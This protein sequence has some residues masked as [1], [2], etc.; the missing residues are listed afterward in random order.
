MSYHTQSIRKLLDMMKKQELL[1]PAFQRKYVWG[2]DRVESL[3]D[4]LMRGYPIGTFLFWEIE[5]E[6][7]N[8]GEYTFYQFMNQINEYDRYRNP[9]AEPHTDSTVSGRRL[10]G[11][12]G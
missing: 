2:P 9:K 11:S 1:L 10:T 4:S 12:K 5:G 3:M 6:A 8:K 7:F